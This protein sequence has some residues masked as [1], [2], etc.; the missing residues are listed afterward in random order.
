MNLLN[1]LF[2]SLKSLISHFVLV[3]L[4]LLI[5]TYVVKEDFFRKRIPKYGGV[6]E[7]KLQG[8][9]GRGIILSTPTSNSVTII[10]LDCRKLTWLTPPVQRGPR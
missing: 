9:T 4:K 5:I 6:G 2:S 8:G 1:V 3:E 7:G 10:L